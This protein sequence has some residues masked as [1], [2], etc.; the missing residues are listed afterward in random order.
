MLSTG[1]YEPEY[2]Q[3]LERVNSEINNVKK[4]HKE[5]FEINILNNNGIVVASTDKA[6]VGYNRSNDA[7]FLKGKEGLYIRDIHISKTSGN[8][9]M[10]IV[11]PVLLN[12]EF[13]GVI[14][15]DLKTEELFKIT[16]DRTGLGETGEAYLVNKD[17]YMI[18]PSRFN[19]D[20]ILKQKVDT[21][22]VKRCLLHKG[23]EHIPELEEKEIAVFPDYRGIT[24]LGTHQYIPQMQWCLLAEIDEKE[25]LAP[26]AKLKLIFSIVMFSVLIIA[27]LIGIFVSRLITKPI[28]NLHKGSEIIG[29]GNLD[30][31]V[32]TEAK[33]EIGRLSRAFDRM[34]ESLKHKTTS[35]DRL[36]KEIAERKKAEAALRESEAKY[37]SMI[38]DVLNS[39]GV[40]I[41]ILDSE[42]KVVWVNRTLETFFDLQRSEVIGK[43]KREIICERIRYVFEEPEKFAETVFSTYDDNTYIERFECHVLAKDKCKERWLEHT[44]NPIKSGFY[45][46]GRIELYV[47]ITE[48]KKV[49]EELREAMSIKSQFTSMVSHELRTPLTAIKEG[50]AIVLD[51]S[52]GKINE[53][54]KDFLSTAKRNV[55]RL[56][57]LINDVLDFTKLES[58]KAEF[59]MEENDINEIIEEIVKTQKAVAGGSGLYLKTNL[60][61][62]IEKIRFDSDKIAQVLTNLIN[63]AIKFTTRGG[64]TVT[65]GIDVEGKAVR[66]Q[67][68][69]TGTGI[70]KENLSR[71]FVEF[72]QVG[73][74]KYRKPGGT[75]LG[76]AICRQIIEGHG[77][78]IRA[79]SEQGRGSKFIF[80]LPIKPEG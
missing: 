67:V 18:S 69:D 30:Y 49:E 64:I 23:K 65:S 71:L 39:S 42:F 59:R 48:R 53:D 5:I 22:N 70:K 45:T 56:H 1:R 17:K 10:D 35:I 43:D 50:I 79:E 7:L 34:T 78:I 37:S 54:Q 40:G 80:T 62:D 20:V 31:K 4:I 32:G 36:N 60:S 29:S 46:G 14:N 26:L 28:H 6:Y 19:E 61:P 16:L 55:D 8:P 76:L 15:I 12:G 3:K 52:A 33:D 58:G 11:S 68:E 77:G 27:W 2:T 9:D 57:R 47:D 25:A 24:V 66:V 41:F 38:N 63:N 13:L 72:Q 73:S 74:D 51:G 44:S 75:G 21:E